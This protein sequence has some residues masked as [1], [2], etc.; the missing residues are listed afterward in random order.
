MHGTNDGRMTSCLVRYCIGVSLWPPSYFEN[1]FKSKKVYIATISSIVDQTLLPPSLP[2]VFS[3]TFSGVG[4]CSSLPGVGLFSTIGMCLGSTTGWWGFSYMKIERG[5]GKERERATS[6]QIA[7]Q[8]TR[9]KNKE[10]EEGMYRRDTYH[11]FMIRLLFFWVFEIAREMWL[12]VCVV[13]WVLLSLWLGV[14]FLL[15]SILQSSRL[16]SLIFII[17]ICRNG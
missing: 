7:F 9:H 15:S 17:M 11:L 14:H 6:H 13:R 2:R 12:I 1:K 16:M 8:S 10:E 3:S 5:K 4:W